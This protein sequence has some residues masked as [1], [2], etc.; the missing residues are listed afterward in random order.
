MSSRKSSSVHGAGSSNTGQASRGLQ[1]SHDLRTRQVPSEESSGRK[2]LSEGGKKTGLEPDIG[3]KWPR[4]WVASSQGW[5][6]FLRS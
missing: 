1:V 6:E 4:W 5:C 2:V 3:N